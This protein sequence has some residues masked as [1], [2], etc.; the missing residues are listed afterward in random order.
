VLSGSNPD[1]N[2]ET[3]DSYTLGVVLQPQFIPGFSFSADYYD[4]TVNNVIVSLGAQAIVNNCYDSPSLDNPFCGLFERYRGP[5]G[6]GPAGETPG[7]VQANT[8]LQSGLNFASRTRRGIDFEA[9]YRGALGQ[10]RIDTSLIYVRVLESSNFQDPLDPNFENVLLGELGSPKNE[11]R[12]DTDLKVGDFTFGYQLRYIGKQYV[13]D[14]TYENFNTT[15]GTP[16][17]NLDFADQFEY[18]PVYYHAI[19]FQWDIANPSVARGGLRFYAGVDNLLNTFPPLGL[20]ATGAPS[21]GTDAIYRAT[22]RTFYAGFR[23][24]F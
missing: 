23:A 21:V 15:N 18:D 12:W 22:G 19:R 13:A 24:R 10:A 20:T 9:A 5:A 7:Q 3:S 2:E 8:L 16:A 4:I 1:L 6:G 17:T 11:F 14:S